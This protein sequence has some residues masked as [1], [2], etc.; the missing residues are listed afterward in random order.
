MDESELR[1]MLKFLID[2]PD[3]TVDVFVGR[4][5]TDCTLTQTFSF[6][7]HNMTDWR[8]A[9]RTYECTASVLSAGDIRLDPE[10]NT[11]PIPSWFLPGIRCELTITE[12]TE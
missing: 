5:A 10:S 9:A 6:E 11:N 3:R 12:A 4:W 2:N 7:L 1:K 8:P